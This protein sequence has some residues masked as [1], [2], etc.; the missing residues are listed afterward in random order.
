[1]KMLRKNS[2]S[3]ALTSTVVAEFLESKSDDFKT[4]TDEKVGKMIVE[5]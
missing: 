1:M 3:S 2:R 5:A 4:G